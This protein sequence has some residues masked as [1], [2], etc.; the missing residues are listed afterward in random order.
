MNETAHLFE[1]TEEAKERVRKAAAIAFPNQTPEPLFDQCSGAGWWVPIKLEGGKVSRNF[2]A[3][4]VPK[5]GV[6]G[7]GIGFLMEEVFPGQG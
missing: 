7:D 6:N 1:N 2:Y 4:H 3:V 5:P